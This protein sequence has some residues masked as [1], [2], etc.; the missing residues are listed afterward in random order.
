VCAQ[1][2]WYAELS[3]HVNVWQAVAR[4]GELASLSLSYFCVFLI[5]Y[6]HIAYE[7]S[8]VVCAQ[9]AWYAE[10]SVHVNVWQAVARRGE[11]ASLSIYFHSM[12]SPP[13]IHSPWV[14][15]G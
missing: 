11:L 14:S 3:V 13:T 5:S 10:L 4:L 15:V 8:T 7:L 9:A 12:R 1:A 2:A 6:T